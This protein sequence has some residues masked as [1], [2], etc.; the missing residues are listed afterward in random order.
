MFSAWTGPIPEASTR[1]NFFL[2]YFVHPLRRQAARGYLRLLKVT[3]TTVIGITGS[4]G[5]TTT[6]EA[7]KAV[8]P[9]SVATLANIDPVYNI[10]ATILATPLGTKYLILEMGIEHLGEMD[11]YLWLA[12]V[13]IAVITGFGLAHTEFLK[14]LQ[15]IKSEKLKITKFAKHVIDFSSNAVEIAKQVARILGIKPDLSHFSPPPHRLQII[16]H[17]SGSTIIDDSYNANPTATKFAI[18]YLV[19]L[20]K[21]KNQ[22][23]VFVFAQMNELGSYKESAH[24]A[25]GKYVTQKGIKHFLTLGPATSKLGQHFNSQE[26]LISATRQFLTPNYCLLIKGSR[27][28]HLETL[29]SAL[30][31]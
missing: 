17:P 16:N 8:L 3:G 15:T 25:I 2:D 12:P 1:H 30:M 6:K 23:P 26:K 29:V 20:S 4:F 9:K 21:E 27:S 28:W 22:T 10:P 13:D 31:A 11:F 19:K 14:D 7:L 18:D 24:A 5:K